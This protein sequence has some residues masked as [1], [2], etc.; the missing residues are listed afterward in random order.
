MTMHV[1]EIS[2]V[3][4]DAPGPRIVGMSNRARNA[5]VLARAH[6]QPIDLA[7]CAHLESEDALL[8]VRSELAI[9]V[10][11]VAALPDPD[12][13]VRLIGPAGG[14][15]ALFGHAEAVRPLLA[16]YFAGEALDATVAVPVLAVPDTAALSLASPELAARA[17]RS[18]LLA[19]AKRTDGVVSRTLN[20]PLSRFFSRIF[21]ALGLR[22]GHASLVNL[23]IGLGCAYCAAQTGYWSMVLAG[24]LFQL[25]SA[26]DGVDGEMA[27]STL[28]ESPRGAWI[29]T[30][31]DNFTY[32]ACLLGV[33]IGW[34][35]EGIGAA[36]LWLA[37]G[38]TLLVPVALLLLMRFVQ[39]YG[40]DGSLVFVDRCVERAAQDSGRASLRIARVLFF[41][42]RRDVFAALF[43]VISWSGARAAVPIAVA[44]GAAVALLT[45]L[46]HRPRLLAA[47][48][49]LGANAT[50]SPAP[51][52][53]AET[54][55]FARSSASDGL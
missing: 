24:T 38:V 42:L 46:G 45:L 40:P 52:I 16:R 18:L 1:P 29:D 10:P 23:L 7:A 27:R 4:D 13:G 50:P 5:R 43:F 28:S 36:Q 26:F 9:N 35:R 21:L 39:R 55:G 2:A 15:Y 12:A 41:A 54:G 3:L 47:A 8:A 19:A 49:A 34:A 48:Q 53:A 44:A 37:A 17:T 25:A 11:L 51:G 20:R 6:V 14:P 33:S 32:V 22:P 31:V 30:A